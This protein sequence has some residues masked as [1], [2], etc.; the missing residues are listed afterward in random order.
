MLYK[1]YVENI[2]CYFFHTIDKLMEQVPK[3]I[4]KKKNSY[5]SWC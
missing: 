1:F 4:Y 5:S 2:V 3:G